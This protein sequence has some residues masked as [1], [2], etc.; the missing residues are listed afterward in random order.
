MEQTIPFQWINIIKLAST[1][2]KVISVIFKD[3]A[4]KTT[5][6]LGTLTA[7][8]EDNSQKIHCCEGVSSH[9]APKQGRE[10]T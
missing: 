3:C 9:P 2:L 7:Q 4:M 6:Q 5:S 10:I 1:I 8:P